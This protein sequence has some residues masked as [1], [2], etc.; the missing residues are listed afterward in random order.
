V[1]IGSGWK[2]WSLP[3][4]ACML[5]GLAACGGGGDSS[6]AGLVRLVNTTLN[7]ASLDL[8][9]GATV[10]VQGTAKDTASNYAGVGAGSPTLQVN[11]AGTATAL[12]TIAPTISG[13]L[14]YAIIVYESNGIVRAAVLGED[15]VAPAAGSAQV[16]ILDVAPEA[17]ALDV[18]VTAPG[19]ALTSPSFTVPAS[20][21]AFTSG[22]L[23]FSAGTFEIRVTGQGNVN[24]LRLD[25]PSVTLTSL[26]TATLVLSASAGGVLVDGAVMV[27]QGAYTASRNPNARVR[28]ATGVL[29][30]AAV[31]A[32]AGA[33]TVINAPVTSPAVGAYTVVPANSA[34]T[35]NVN[36]VVTPVT[37][38]LTAGSDATLL[39][40]GT[41]A[42]PTSKL[43]VDD[44]HL[45]STNTVYKMRLVNGLTGAA[46]TQTLTADF[47]VIASGV[48]PNS[49]S[50]YGTGQGSTAVRLDVQPI[51]ITT[52]T[53]NILN[54]AVYSVFV[55]GDPAVPVGTVG[56][57][58]VPTQILRR[59][60]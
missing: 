38:T 18:Y 7:H 57:A 3:L 40:T 46:T 31:G 42:A 60:R 50:S 20:A 49:A 53:L 41:A 33:S 55:F 39:V 26:Q 21:S 58:N 32:V 23:T 44:N 4:A 25:I 10:V 35:V 52:S 11:D 8:A 36:G 47:A 9:V 5:L 48:A 1:R 59:D 54:N 17:G 27:Q 51:G 22:L 13:S 24:D 30:S 2:S 14:H 16:R 12:T 37:G 56:N 34:L 19:A 28:L 29:N 43:I 15:N 6:S 45:P